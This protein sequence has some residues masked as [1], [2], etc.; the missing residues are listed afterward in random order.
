M[1][2]PKGMATLTGTLYLSLL[3]FGIFSF[4]YVPSII[5]VHGDI[6]ETINN[7]IEHEW[8]FR[9]GTIS[10]LISQVLVVFLALSMFR[11]FKYV[12]KDRT[13]LMVVLAL[14]GLPVAFLNEVHNLAVIRLL[15]PEYN[16][17]TSDQL[18]AQVMLFLDMSR[19]GVLIA[20]IFWGLWLLPLGLLVYKSGFLPKLLGILVLIAGCAYLFDSIMQLLLPGFLLISRFTFIFEIILPIWLLVKGVDEVNW[21]KLVPKTEFNN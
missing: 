18:N 15:A 21:K 4:V 14:L 3:P 2:S 11:L 6:S 7:I 17:F 19:N 20:Q 1:T 8:I 13:V 12:N 10:H 16:M 5:F 9:M